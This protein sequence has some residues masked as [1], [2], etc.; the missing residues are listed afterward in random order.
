V[1]QFVDNDTI[2]DNHAI[3][4]PETL[5]RLEKHGK[6]IHRHFFILQLFLVAYAL[7]YSQ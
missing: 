6:I 4:T 2:N 3:L 5:N 7:I 1:Y